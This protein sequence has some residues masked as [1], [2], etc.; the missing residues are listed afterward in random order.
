VCLRMKRKVPESN[1]EENLYPLIGPSQ[2]SP[3]DDICW[4]PPLPRDPLAL[5]V[6][7]LY[8][9][10]K[11]NASIIATPYAH[12][13]NQVLRDQ[14]SVANGWRT[15]RRALD[16]VGQCRSMSARRLHAL[17]EPTSDVTKSARRCAGHFNRPRYVLVGRSRCH[18]GV[19]KIVQ[20]RDRPVKPYN[21]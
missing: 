2:L 1:E 9:W 13:A 15:I 14:D 3:R 4:S 17:L 5:P 16:F 11:F 20:V 6:F 10:P 21:M 12:L 19:P 8:A 7:S 18:G